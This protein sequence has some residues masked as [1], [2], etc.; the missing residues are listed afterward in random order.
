MSRVSGIGAAPN[1][2]STFREMAQS[3]LFAACNRDDCNRFALS[4]APTIAYLNLTS[5]YFGLTTM[6]CGK[7]CLINFSFA[8]FVLSCS[9]A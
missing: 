3:A 7:R 8:V 1:P 9:E 4:E 5:W 2:H 6:N